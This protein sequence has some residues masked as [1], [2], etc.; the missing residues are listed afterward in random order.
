MDGWMR[1]WAAY[2]GAIVRGRERREGRV[3][4]HSLTLALWRSARLG[5]LEPCS[6]KLGFW[7]EAGGGEAGGG[8]ALALTT[9]ELLCE[10][11]WWV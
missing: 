10:R 9:I 7:G 5:M 2:V 4:S 11:R 1:A 3:G 8:G 6:P